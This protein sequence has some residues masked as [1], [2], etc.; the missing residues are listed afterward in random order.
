MAY[1]D[2]DIFS[3]L[4]MRISCEL[5]L[6]VFRCFSDLNSA[7]NDVIYLRIIIIIMLKHLNK[8]L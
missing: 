2:V 8:L 7:A 6:E 1:D 5:K 4:I 3:G